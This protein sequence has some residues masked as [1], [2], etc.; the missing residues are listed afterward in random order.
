MTAMTG[1]SPAQDDAAEGTRW[2]QLSRGDS[3]YLV[4]QLSDEQRMIGKSAGE[5]C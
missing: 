1:I 4:D 5:R 3:F 2:G